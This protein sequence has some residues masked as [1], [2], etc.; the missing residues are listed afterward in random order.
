MI[1]GYANGYAGYIPPEEAFRWGGYGVDFYPGDPPEYGRTALPKGAGE[2]I[3]GEL[4]ALA[5]TE[6]R[7]AGCERCY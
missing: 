3:F 7:E 6:L 2:R 1:V 4:L 5:R